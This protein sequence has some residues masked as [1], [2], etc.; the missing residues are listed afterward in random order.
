MNRHLAPVRTSAV[1]RYLAAAAALVA[2]GSAGAATIELEVGGIE[3]ADGRLMVALFPSAERFRSDSIEARSLPARAG[4]VSLRFDGLPPGE[5]AFT[6]FH[7]RNGNGVLDTNLMGLPLEPAAAS[8]EP[9]GFGP[10]QWSRARFV[11]PAD[12][13]RVS[14]RLPR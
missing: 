10:P 12:G 3:S 8:G 13:A 6:V 9:G 11:V 4:A 14:V 7:D 5:Y 2:C 1:R